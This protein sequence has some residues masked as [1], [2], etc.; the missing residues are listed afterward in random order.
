MR[1][2]VLLLAAAGCTLLPCPAAPLTPADREALIEKLDSLRDGVQTKATAKFQAAITAYRSAMGSPD[3]TIG[4]Y[5]KCVEKVDFSDQNRKPADFRAWKRRQGDRLDDPS[6]ALAL[7]HQLRW[8]TLTLQAS[9]PKA[10]GDKIAADA[11]D[12]IQGMCR[13][14]PRLKTQSGVLSQPVLSTVFARAYGITAVHDKE[15]PE[16][17]LPIDRIYQRII[18]P[19][20]RDT[21]RID[22]LQ[23]AWARR[24]EQ[25]GLIVEN[26]V[27]IGRDGRPQD[28]DPQAADRFRTET[29]PELEWRK[30][31]DLYQCGDE[32]GAAMRML[33]HIETNI[34]HRS[35]R[36]WAAQF[37]ELLKP[38]SEPPAETAATR[39]PRE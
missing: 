14:L 17:L 34:T 30:E 19:P 20:L 23:E 16:S 25:E 8:L 37:R 1:K 2:P 9:T 39:P 6:Y 21:N 11:A 27:P 32:R 3:A 29:R 24:I 15:W 7:R 4:F 18:L 28:P 13:E 35:A 10:N 26:L 36:E 5:L 38:N 33:D 12:L 22:S 31:L